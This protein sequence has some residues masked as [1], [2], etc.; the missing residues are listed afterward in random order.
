MQ[1]FFQYD[2]KRWLVN[3]AGMAGVSN[4]D[5][6]IGNF[7]AEALWEYK[8][9]FVEPRTLG[10]ELEG[11]LSERQSMTLQIECSSGGGVVWDETVEF[12]YSRNFYEYQPSS[13]DTIAGNYTLRV[14]PATNTLNINA[15]GV[16]FSMYRN[17]PRCTVN[18]QVSL[19]DTRYNLYWMEWLFSSCSQDRIDNP[20]KGK[21]REV[22]VAR[23]DPIDPVSPHQNGGMYVVQYVAHAEKLVANAP[24]QVAW[25]RV[26]A[27][28]FETTTAGSMKLGVPVGRIEQDVGVDNAQSAAFHGGKKLVAV[29]HIDPRAA[30]GPRGQCR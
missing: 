24:A 27:Q 8:N 3:G 25:D 15:D 1:G 6:A 19:I 12:D 28:I 21:P 11:T 16:V 20:R 13:L 23:I 22:G 17:G 4:G 18:G 9:T 29:R 30:A 10:C 2:D 7:V 5:R 26:C 14:M